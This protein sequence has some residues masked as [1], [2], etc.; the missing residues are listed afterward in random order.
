MINFG[1]IHLTTSFHKFLKLVQGNSKRKRYEFFLIKRTKSFFCLSNLS[2]PLCHFMMMSSS[3][4]CPWFPPSF[5][6]S[7]PLIECK[8]P[9]ILT[10]LPLWML[11]NSIP[12]PTLPLL[13]LLYSPPSFNMCPWLTHLGD[14]MVTDCLN[15][16]PSFHPLSMNVPTH[17]RGCDPFLSIWSW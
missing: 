5:T 11:V 2:Q 14:L 12:P 7:L 15:H 10:R 8:G 3:C 4:A 6:P 17:V 16:P 1:L 9:D 13:A